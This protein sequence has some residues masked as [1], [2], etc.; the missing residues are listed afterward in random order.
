MTEFGSMSLCDEDDYGARNKLSLP[1]VA[2]GE[3]SGRAFKPEVR[4]NSVKFS[5]TGGCT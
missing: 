1:G 4:V 2:R 5:P 3:F